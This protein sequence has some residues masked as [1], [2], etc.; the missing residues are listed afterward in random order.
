MMNAI[1]LHYCGKD[2]VIPA[3]KAFRAAAQLEDV[4]RLAD[5]PE[6]QRRPP[7]MKIAE[8]YGVLL[9]FAGCYVSNEE[10]WENMAAGLFGGSGDGASAAIR[11]V[12]A[13]TACLMNGAPDMPVGGDAGKKTKALSKAASKSP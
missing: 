12:E 2:Y 1:R 5:I 3:D 4:V 7:M 11:A 8:A 13:L 9:R 6:W 10:V